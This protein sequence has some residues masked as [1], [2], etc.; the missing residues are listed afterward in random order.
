M[1]TPQRIRVKYFF[2][3]GEALDPE[4]FIPVFHRWIQQKAVDEVLIDVVDYK[5]VAN[6]PAIMLIGHE[7]DY[8]LDFEKGKPGLAYTRKRAVGQDLTAALERALQQARRGCALLTSR[9]PV[10]QSI[11]FRTDLVEVALLDRLLYP[12]APG[13]LEMVQETFSEV[14][15]RVYEDA[16]FELSSAEHDQR[17]PFT[18]QIVI[19]QPVSPT[20]DE[21][22]ADLAAE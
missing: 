6:G 17:L 1:M 4:A 15:A 18:V 19:H 5:H 12:N 8:V 10:K 9:P 3:D 20:T 14:L 16:T 11:A 7:A 13:T 2:E 22:V 21:A